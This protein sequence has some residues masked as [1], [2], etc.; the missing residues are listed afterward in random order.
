MSLSNFPENWEKNIPEIKILPEDYIPKK[1]EIGKKY[2]LSWASSRAM[3]WVLKS[4]NANYVF[5][6]TPKTKKLLVSKISDLRELNK[7]VLMNAKQRI[8]KLKIKK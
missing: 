5:L 8:N 3:V 7:Y 1:L 2:H 4:Y 6:E